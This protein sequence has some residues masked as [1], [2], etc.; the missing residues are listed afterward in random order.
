MR[1]SRFL[2]VTGCLAFCAITQLH[3]QA[4]AGRHPLPDFSGFWVLDTAHSISDGS[5]PML[6]LTPFIRSGDTLSLLGGGVNAGGSI[7][8]RTRY[9]LVA[10]MRSGAALTSTV[11]WDSATMIVRSSGDA[12][13]NQIVI[14]DRWSLDATRQTLTQQSSFSLNGQV[15]SETLVFTKRRP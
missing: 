9:S 15:R 7:P 8:G 13:G 11:T 3:G 1:L 5:L 4:G 6:T 12:N 10:N 14:V 2:G